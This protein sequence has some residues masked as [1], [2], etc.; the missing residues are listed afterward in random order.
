M[1]AELVAQRIKKRPR[2]ADS[3]NPSQHQRLVELSRSAGA[4]GA[5]GPAS[6]DSFD[7][8]RYVAALGKAVPAVAAQVARR[9]LRSLNPRRL[10][11]VVS[12]ASS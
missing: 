12:W 4:F 7:E 8:K 3:L 5:P 1:P 11:V 10:A 9:L 6:G 2:L